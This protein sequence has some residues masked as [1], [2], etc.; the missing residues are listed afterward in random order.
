MPINAAISTPVTPTTQQCGSTAAG[1]VQPSTPSTDHHQSPRAIHRLPDTR[2]VTSHGAGRVCVWDL[3]AKQW[4]G[5]LGFLPDGA[6]LLLA[7]GAHDY[8]DTF[9]QLRFGWITDARYYAECYDRPNLPGQ[10]VPG[11]WSRLGL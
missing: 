7:D 8:D 1:G 6:W 9:E 11:L 4:I 2:L 10:R 5:S 3:A